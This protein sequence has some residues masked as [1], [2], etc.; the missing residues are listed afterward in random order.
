MCPRIMLD[1]SLF[2]FKLQC[3]HF[4]PFNTGILTDA[5]SFFMLYKLHFFVV[6]ISYNK[7]REYWILTIV[8]GIDSKEVEF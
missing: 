8:L 4:Q 2:V 6:N 5:L 3:I 1:Q 7:E